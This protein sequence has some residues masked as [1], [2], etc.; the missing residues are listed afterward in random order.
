[1]AAWGEDAGME[2]LPDQRVRIE[3]AVKP[4]LCFGEVTLQ[5]I[6]DIDVV[7]GPQDY[8]IEFIENGFGPAE[9]SDLVGVARTGNDRP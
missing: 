6:V 5:V 2:E 9:V 7:I 3:A 1:M 4:N 8:G